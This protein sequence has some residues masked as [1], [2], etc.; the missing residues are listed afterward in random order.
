MKDWLK[1]NVAFIMALY[2]VFVWSIASLF[3]LW[4]VR[5][6]TTLLV[7]LYASSIGMP[8]G[9]VLGYWYS[10]SSGSAK[11]TEILEAQNKTP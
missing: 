9:L 4:I 2:V 10:S 3:V 1:N 8:I 6:N 5:E 11:K 7:A